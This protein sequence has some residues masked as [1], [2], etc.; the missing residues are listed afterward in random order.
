M[1]PG[2]PVSRLA[3]VLGLAL[4]VGLW[5]SPANSPRASAAANAPGRILFVRDTG[6]WVW[7]NGD[8]TPVLK[9]DGLRDARWSPSGSQIIF[10]QT[11]NSYSD[12]VVYD[13]QGKTQTPVT[14]NQANYEEG[15]PEYVQTS[16][17]ALDPDWTTAG[18]I[19][20]MSDFAS[21]DGTFQLWLV[22][23]SY[24][25]YLAPAA[26]FE[27]NISSLSMSA[28][29]SLA[30]Y[31][32]QERQLDGSSVN[33]VVLRDLM[34][35]IAYPLASGYDAF[36]PSIAPDQQTVALA[37]RSDDGSTSDIF[38]VNR[39]TGDLVRIT[40]DLQATNPTWSPDGKWLAFIRMIDYEFEVWASP[41]I[42]GQPQQP[43]KLFKAAG[44]DARS[45]ISWT[46]N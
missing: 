26:Q 2:H 38:T 16:A 45:G 12:L 43:V 21:A 7:Q 35:G 39:A 23:Q 30:A 24:S 40:Q 6:I 46:L 28:D 14:Y 18:I 29:A 11:G 20:F 15:T 9:G 37:I 1:K 33:R 36:D 32:V 25:P 10:V 4:S 8:V 42:N 34:D 27:D 44:L 31:E 22:D 13:L 19:G 17:W 41:M 3:L 5:G